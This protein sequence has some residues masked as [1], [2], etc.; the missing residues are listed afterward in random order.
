MLLRVRNAA[1][2]MLLLAGLLL[3]AL[4]WL[5]ASI[6][7]HNPMEKRKPPQRAPDAMGLIYQDVQVQA[8]DGLV[9]HGWFVPGRNGA[10]VM[11]QHGYKWHREGHLEEARL[12]HDAGYN[13]LVTS[14]RAHDINAGDLISFGVRE[15]QD[16]D[17]WL[18]F[19]QLQLPIDT[20]RIGMLG[21]SLGGSMV[22]QFAA[23]NPAIRAVVTHSAFSSLQDTIDT[24]VQHFTGL[25]A[26]PFAPLI[27]WWAERIVG[28]DVASVDAT[29]WIA[30]L[31][32]RPVLI[33][34]SIT[35]TVISPDSGQRLFDAAGEPRELWL[36]AGVDHAA[37]DKSHPQ[38]FA[39]RVTGFFDRSLQ[40][41]GSMAPAPVSSA[42][43]P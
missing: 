37:F 33:I 35:D 39:R 40:P 12:L 2:G 25:P 41:D 21:D 7:V 15:M 43:A 11:L 32:P 31:A 36:A 6:L 29:R 13:V 8:A 42:D 18:A 16:L 14:V 22:L 26:F 4:C 1:L 34:H 19:A 17:A 30:A 23:A 9:L 27:A 38:E 24:S 3:N 20:S 5:Q 28:F 10:L